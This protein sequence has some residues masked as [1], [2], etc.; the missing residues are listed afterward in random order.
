MVFLQEKWLNMSAVVPLES[1]EIDEAKGTSEYV[2]SSQVFPNDTLEHALELKN[3][4]GGDMVGV[5][6]R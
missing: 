2:K 3:M 5:M 4:V 1:F 6:L